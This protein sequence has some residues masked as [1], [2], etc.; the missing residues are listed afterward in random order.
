MP[1]NAAGPA[2]AF[3]RPSLILLRQAV[4]NA[5]E[6]HWDR[7][8]RLIDFGLSCSTRMARL[9]VVRML[10]RMAGLGAGMAPLL[11]PKVRN[12]ASAHM[13]S[14]SLLRH[15]ASALITNMMFDAW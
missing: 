7:L 9:A 5:L 14:R 3:E 15:T 8:E 13:C 2:H 4:A 10:T 6:V 11:G 1:A 12:A